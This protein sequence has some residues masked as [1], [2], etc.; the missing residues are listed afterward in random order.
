MTVTG[1]PWGKADSF[2]RPRH[3]V[4]AGLAPSLGPAALVS[5]ERTAVL[6]KARRGVR[7]DTLNRPREPDARLYL[8]EELYIVTARLPASPG[9][10]AEASAR[11]FPTIG[12]TTM[13][14]QQTED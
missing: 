2:T 6:P 11:A 14:W 13:I 12:R 8:S 10:G 1:S 3:R 4:D 7:L 5:P 9:R